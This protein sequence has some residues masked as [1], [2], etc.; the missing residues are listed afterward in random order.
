MSCQQKSPQPFSGVSHLKRDVRVRQGTDTHFPS[1]RDDAHVCSIQFSRCKGVRA[2]EHMF[3][4]LV[5]HMC[6]KTALQME[7]VGY[8]LGKVCKQIEEG[9]W[10]RRF[11]WTPG[12]HP[13]SQPLLPWRLKPRASK[14]TKSACA[15][16]EWVSKSLS[17]GEDPRANLHRRGMFTHHSFAFH[18]SRALN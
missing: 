1:T 10:R 9:T 12:N 16:W 14:N 7:F 18:D 13:K 5:Y 11:L 17:C 8:C 3:S 2:L 6:V 15:D 4:K